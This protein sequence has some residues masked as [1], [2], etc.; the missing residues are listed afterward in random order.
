M[1]HLLLAGLLLGA[2]LCLLL[3]QTRIQQFYLARAGAGL[4]PLLLAWV[5][6]L[7]VR[8][9]RQQQWVRAGALVLLLATDGLALGGGVLLMATTGAM[10]GP[11]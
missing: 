3:P 2:F 10:P 4:A 1:A 8:R 7:L 6:V 11:S 9:L 5:G